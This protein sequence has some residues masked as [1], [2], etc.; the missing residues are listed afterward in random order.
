VTP[1]TFC[2]ASFI[3]TFETGN[4]LIKV[5]LGTVACHRR[6]HVCPYRDVFCGVWPAFPRHRAHRSYL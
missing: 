1:A 2:C 4:A 5:L 6:L 3:G